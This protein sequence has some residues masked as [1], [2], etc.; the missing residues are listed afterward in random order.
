MRNWLHMW[1]CTLQC[2]KAESAGRGRSEGH[3]GDTQSHPTENCGQVSTVG[4]RGKPESLHSLCVNKKGVVWWEHRPEMRQKHSEPSLPSLDRVNNVLQPRPTA[5]LHPST[6]T[7]LLP[8]PGRQKRSVKLKLVGLPKKVTL[9][10]A[11]SSLKCLAECLAPSGTHERLLLSG[12]EIQ[13][14]ICPEDKISDKLGYEQKI[15]AKQGLFKA[16]QNCKL[17]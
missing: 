1:T 7:L 2:R 5:T 11:S 13:G 10:N 8:A 15:T 14:W 17:W 16:V 12:G 9:L 6:G 4:G 3:H